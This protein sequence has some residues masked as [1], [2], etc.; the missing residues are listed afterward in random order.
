MNFKSQKGFTGADVTVAVLIVT[1][2][3]G[4]IASL[5]GNYSTTSK[6]IE[7]KSEASNYAIETIEQIK[8]ESEKYFTGDN[9]TN[10]E[11]TVYN[12]EQI[13]NTPYSRTAIIED[14]KKSNQEAKARCCKRS[15]S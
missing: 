11:I 9:E 12:N 2:F 3:A 8:S 10:E 1:I 15:K 6:Q 7:R 13:D 5:Y 14:Y 4:I